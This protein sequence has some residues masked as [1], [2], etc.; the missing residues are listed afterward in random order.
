MAEPTPTNPAQNGIPAPASQAP[1]LP[2]SQPSQKSM[3]KAER[4][5]LQEK[6]RAAKALQKQ[7][8][9]QGG[10]GGGQQQKQKAE[11]KASPKPPAM[12]SPAPKSQTSGGRPRSESS[13]A[14]AAQD[15]ALDSTRRGLRIFTHFGLPKLPGGA[16][17]IKGSDI[18]HPAVLRL[19]LMFSEFKICGANARCIA[20]LTAFKTV[21]LSQR[22]V[23]VKVHAC[24]G[25]SRLHYPSEYY[26]LKTFDDVS[27][28]SDFTSRCCTSHVSHDGQCD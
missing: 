21:S 11:A 28:T 17:H 10:G 3:T 19:G 8:Q 9:Q 27:V 15:A 25:Y 6:Q 5:E 13:A 1:N 18:I 14:A 12:K 7:Q 16:H 26:P 4:R 22:P 2:S 20:T 24:S 23:Y